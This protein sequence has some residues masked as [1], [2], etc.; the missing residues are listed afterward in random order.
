MHRQ[1]LIAFDPFS[2]SSCIWAS[3]RWHR[4]AKKP[5]SC[6]GMVERVGSRL[7]ASACLDKFT[8]PR[9]CL[10]DNPRIHPCT[11]PLSWAEWSGLWIAWGKRN[12]LYDIASATGIAATR[13]KMTLY[14]FLHLSSVADAFV[15]W[16][17]IQ[18]GIIGEFLGEKKSWSYPKWESNGL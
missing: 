13:E 3:G 4:W 1:N 9:P 15:N 7:C 14:P 6:T 17:T 16:K 18:I 2:C 12:L 11:S 8:Q 5:T 10:C